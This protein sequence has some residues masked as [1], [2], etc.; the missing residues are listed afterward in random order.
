MKMMMLLVALL[1]CAESSAQELKVGGQA[2]GITV[3][4]VR[5]KVKAKLDKYPNPLFF[6]SGMPAGKN[7]TLQ[8][9][10]DRIG[11]ATVTGEGNTVNIRVPLSFDARVDWF[12]RMLFKVKHHEDMHG[13]F[14]LVATLK[15][16]AERGTDGSC[17][18]ATTL[19]C[20]HH[21]TQKP[22]IKVGPVPIRISGKTGEALQGKL[23]PLCQTLN[24]AIS[25]KQLLSARA[26]L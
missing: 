26:C 19:Q 17:Q 1:W 23:V 2:L 18:L 12:V 25:R 20:N 3:D 14:A 5:Q 4:D 9:K 8:L 7:T 21:W 10:V 11:E 6:K 16:S 24:Q 22:V 13:E 15:M